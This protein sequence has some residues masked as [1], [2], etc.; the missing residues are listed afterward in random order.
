MEA[1]CHR[2]VPSLFLSVMGG[3]KGRVCFSSGFDCKFT[4][5][6]DAGRNPSGSRRLVANTSARSF[7]SHWNLLERGSWEGDHGR[8]GQIGQFSDPAPFALSEM[9][10]YGRLFSRLPLIDRT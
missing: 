10:R 7:G 1:K 9:E 4:E 5:L 6:N 3:Y 8:T 2:R